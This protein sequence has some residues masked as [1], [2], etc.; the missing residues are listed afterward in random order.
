MK[1]I[2][3]MVILITVLLSTMHIVPADGTNT[4][5]ENKKTLGMGSSDTINYVIITTDDLKDAVLPLK[6][7]KEYL[8]YTIE[9]I[10]VSWIIDTYTGSDVQEQIRNFLIDTYSD[11]GIDYVLIV[12]SR[13]TIPMRICHPIPS[14]YPDYLETDYYYADLTGDW[15]ADH[16]GYY[17]EYEDDDVDFLAELSIGRLPSDV[18]ETVASI[19][20]NI[21][22]FESDSGDWKKNALLLGAIIYYENL[23]SFEWVYE[24]SD[25]ATV[26]EEC[27][28][29][30][31]EPHGFSCTRMYEADGIRPSTYTFDYPLERSTVISEWQKGYGIVNMLG[32]SNEKLASRFIWDHDD[33]DDIP[34]INEGEL[35]Y[36][37]IL[38]STDARQLSLEKPPI[39]FSAGCSQL[40]TSNNMGRKFMESSA[41][42]AYV[43]TTDLGFYNITR[44][45]RD[46]SDGGA[47]SLD[48]YFFDYLINDNESCGD[49]LCHSKEVFLKRF[50]FTTYD[51]DWI[52]RCYSTLYGFTLYGDPSLGLFSEK[53]DENPPA[54]T[55]VRPKNCAYIF[56]KE[57]SFLPFSTPFIVGGITLNVTAMDAEAGVDSI[58]IWVDDD[59]KL[60]VHDTQVTWFWDELTYGRHHLQIVACDTAGNTATYDQEV[61]IFNFNI[62]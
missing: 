54:I 18:P 23:E 48:Y 44:V 34:E 31:F 12:G 36:L 50:M 21:V 32:H 61:V 24:R 5:D 59:L 22:T 20:E 17:G 15:D 6:T 25:G 26:M 35:V 52:Y 37:D 19:C 28:S 46:E 14:V 1:N 42:V 39:V 55:L 7:W 47:F 8:G 27:R 3:L 49:A 4:F 60:D 45:W 30:I 43:G 40:H 56:D 51:P 33:G 62:V 2:L 53:K 11:W 16:D 38:R 9:I 57:I 58:E 41:A 29:D 10:T 13:N